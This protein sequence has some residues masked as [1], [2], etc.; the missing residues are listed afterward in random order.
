MRGIGPFSALKTHQMGEIVPADRAPHPNLLP[1][2]GAK[3]LRVRE[4]QALH[5]TQLAQFRGGFGD[6]GWRG[7]SRIN[8]L[9]GARG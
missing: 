5:L 8:G 3:E 6:F 9:E 7:M 2:S 1:A 4:R